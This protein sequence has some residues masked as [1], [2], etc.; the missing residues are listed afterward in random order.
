MATVFLGLGSNM[1]DRVRYLCEAR[2]AIRQEVGEIVAGSSV[3]ENEAVGF[4]GNTFCNQVIKVETTLPPENLL[5]KTQEIEQKM[6]RT[7]K[8][9]LAQGTPIYSNRIIDIDILLYDDLQIDTETLTIPHPRMPEREFVMKLLN[10][11]ER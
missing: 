4:T 6:G 10:E 2:N 9:T 1:G 3:L 5:Q 7:E 11:I 8:T